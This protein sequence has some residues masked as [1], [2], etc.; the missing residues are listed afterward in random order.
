MM[1]NGPKQKPLINSL[2]LLLFATLVYLGLSYHEI[3]LDEAHHYLFARDS[4]S[5]S[6]LRYNMRYDG[7]PILWNCL[8]FFITR[9]SADVVLMQYLHLIIITAA[10]AVFTFYAPFDIWEKILFLG[11]YFILYEY[12]VISRNYAIYIL[13]LFLAIVLY[14]KQRHVFLGITLAILANTH[15]FGL[16]TALCFAGMVAYDVIFE[17]L[18]HIDRTIWI[19]AVIVTLGAILSIVQVI[20]PSESFIYTNATG[21]PVWER[22]AR[23]SAVF[24]KAWIPIPDFTGDHFWNSNLLM[25]FSKPLC[26]VLS[27]ALM[28]VPL[29]V[30]RRR[31]SLLLFFYGSTGAVLL[32]L[33]LSNLNATRYYGVIY[34]LFITA[35]WLS[36]TIPEPIRL[37]VFLKRLPARDD[38]NKGFLLTLLVLQMIGGIVAYTLDLTRPFSESRYAAEWMQRDAAVTDY[39]TPGCGGAPI[40]AYLGQKMYYLNVQEYRSFCLFSLENSAVEIPERFKKDALDF[41]NK[42]GRPAFLVVH[43]PFE[44]NAEDSLRFR[45]EQDFAWSVLRNERYYVYRVLAPR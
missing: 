17:K 9:L 30:F 18:H 29:Y 21:S 38:L 39:L 41:V 12:A 40:S 33:Y 42:T 25:E 45:H 43:E 5:L 27:I 1:S 35:W 14:G 11:G 31:L 3:W 24:L 22:L 15:L 16:V 28:A 2:L 8:L 36:C 34:V 44:L 20:P 7:H 10:M 13:F 23:T 32:F 26:S 19:G 4:Q 6:D 37:P